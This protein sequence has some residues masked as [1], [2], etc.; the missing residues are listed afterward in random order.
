MLEHGSQF[1]GAVA[2]FLSDGTDGV[3]H[4]AI[5]IGHRRLVP[6]TRR[7]RPAAISPPA[8]PARRMSRF[9]GRRS[10]LLGA[11]VLDQA[12][13]EERAFRLFDGLQPV[14]ETREL[15]D[16]VAIDLRQPCFFCLVLRWWERSW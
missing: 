1:V 3:E 4:R 16:V 8:R 9:S 14:E 2:D 6:P 7:C 15:G 10:P 13:V 11:A 5:E 12:M